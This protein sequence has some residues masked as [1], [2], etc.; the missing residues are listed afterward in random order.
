MLFFSRYFFNFFIADVL[1]GRYCSV[2][3]KYLAMV[4]QMFFL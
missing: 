1:A 4:M 3:T 2:Y